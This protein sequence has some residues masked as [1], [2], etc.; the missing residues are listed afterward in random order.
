[1]RPSLILGAA[2]ALALLL[3]L[4]P[5][6]SRKS[7]APLPRAEPS[8]WAVGVAEPVAGARGGPMPEGPFSKQRRPPCLASQEAL[9][10]GCWY[11]LAQQPP[12]G[13]EQYESRGACF[14]PVLNTG[15][16]GMSSPR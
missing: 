3:L 16:L 7:A 10:G 14:L 4:L 5:L 8:V 6:A 15:S 2:G 9:N 12:C 1:M 11:R 13:P